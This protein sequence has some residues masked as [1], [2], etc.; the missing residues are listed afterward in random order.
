MLKRSTRDREV[1]EDEGEEAR[2]TEEVSST[3][4]KRNYV[5]GR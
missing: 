5:K 4:Q 2:D 1:E 3:A